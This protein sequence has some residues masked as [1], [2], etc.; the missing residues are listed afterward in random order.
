[1]IDLQKVIR[2]VCKVTDA[3]F[4]P[5]LQQ[6]ISAK[7]PAQQTLDYPLELK[8]ESPQNLQ[9]GA[10]LQDKLSSIIELNSNAPAKTETQVKIQE[11]LK[12][13]EQ[14]TNIVGKDVRIESLDK[15]M[16]ESNDEVQNY[17]HGIE[18]FN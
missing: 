9:V 11:Q 10:I 16:K 7:T 13:D 4:S 5:I 15:S 14:M 3:T 8:L 12:S 2:E 1:V 17:I 18:D 6:S